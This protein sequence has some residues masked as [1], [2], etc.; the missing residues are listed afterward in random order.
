VTNTLK[1]TLY[2]N[3]KHAINITNHV[4]IML[5]FRFRLDPVQPLTMDKANYA[6]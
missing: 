6:K 5:L 2:Q 4:G 1:N 3:T